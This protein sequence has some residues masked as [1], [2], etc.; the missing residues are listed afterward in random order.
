MRK[1][2]GKWIVKLTA[3]IDDLELRDLVRWFNGA[4]YGVGIAGVSAI[5]TAARPSRYAVIDVFALI[6]IEHHYNPPWI[7]LVARDKGGNPEATDESYAPYIRFYLERAKEQTSASCEDWTPRN[8][9]MALWAIGKQV[10]DGRKVN[11]R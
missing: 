3:K 10:S 11:C 7:R 9:D 2:D 8:V 1:A 6:A 5:F 4:V